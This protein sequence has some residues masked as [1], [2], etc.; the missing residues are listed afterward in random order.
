MYWVKIHASLS[1]WWMIL[2]YY[3]I[4]AHNCN[5]KLFCHKIN[6]NLPLCKNTCLVVYLINVSDLVKNVFRHYDIRKNGMASLTSRYEFSPLGQSCSRWGCRSNLR[7][8]YFYRL[9]PSFW[10]VST[11]LREIQSFAL[12][13]TCHWNYTA[14]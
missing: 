12:S 5:L 11:F 6:P 9:C 1:Y 3:F 8:C 4:F 14:A 10:F 2:I 7:G 13:T